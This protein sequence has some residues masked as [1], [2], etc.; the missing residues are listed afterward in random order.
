MGKTRSAYKIMGKPEMKSPEM[1]NYRI[2]S[3]RAKVVKC[4]VTS[5]ASFRF[6]SKQQIHNHAILN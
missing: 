5:Y 1:G 3:L 6:M 4:Q 2:I